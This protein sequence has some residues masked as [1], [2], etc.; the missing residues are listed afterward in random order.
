MWIEILRL[1]GLSHYIRVTLLAE[2]VDRNNEI[3]KL[4]I[5]RSKVTLLAEGVDRNTVAYSFGPDSTVT[6]LAEGVDRNEEHGW[7]IGVCC[8]HPPRGGCG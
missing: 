2:G 4:E 1:F 6:L 5:S 8:S 7:V 3:P